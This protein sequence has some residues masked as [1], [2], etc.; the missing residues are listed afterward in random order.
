MLA[1]L[2][3]GLTYRETAEARGLSAKTVNRHVEI[4]FNKIGVSSRAAAV[5]K[6]LKA[7]LI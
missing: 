3:E 2:A 6:A 4:I 1:R 7:G 5:A